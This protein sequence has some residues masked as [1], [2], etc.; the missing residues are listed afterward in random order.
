VIAIRP[1]SDRWKGPEARILLNRFPRHRSARRVSRRAQPPATTGAHAPAGGPPDLLPEPGQTAANRRRDRVFRFTLMAADLVA[2]LL[3]VALSTVWLPTSQ[4]GWT[5]LFVV[6]LLPVVHGVSGLYERDA[7]VLN[8]NT[9]D[10]APATFRAATTTTILAFLLQS[11]VLRVPIGATVVGFVWLGLTVLVPACRVLGRALAR[12]LLSPERCLVI[13][14][15]AEAQRVAAKLGDAVGLKSELVGV[16]PLSVAAPDG[17]G[18]RT[19][20]FASFAERVQ[21]HDVHRVLVAVGAGTPQRELEAVQA[22]KAAGAKVSVL[23]RVLEVVGSSASFDFI[24][25]LTVLGVPEFGMSSTAQA[26]KR[27]FDVAGSALLILLASPLLVAIALAVKLTSAGPV[28]FRQERVGR[29]GERFDMLKFRSMHD[30]ADALKDE[31]RHANEQD[32]LFKIADDPRITR[33]GRLLRRTSLDE[34]P[35]IFNVLRSDMS[36]VGPRP[37]VPEEDRRI[38][39]WSR[40]RLHLTPGM[41][42]PWQVLGS[43]RIPLREMVAIDYL[44][45]ANWS[46][47][48]DVKIMLRTVGVVVLRRGR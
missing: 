35:Q 1:G 27:T 48:N 9:L 14:D 23:P 3:V 28:F 45:V 15:D 10:E 37:L 47:W 46:L 22:A 17:S 19:E 29:N 12:A 5:A 13:G 11:L 31:L 30:G 18:P 25:G 33:V 36:M 7:K 39:G 43:S 2:A 20:E 26:L 4:L 6:V 24:D 42:G 34:L 8:K 21:R 16:E 44:Y 32:G 41:T 38:R 40:R